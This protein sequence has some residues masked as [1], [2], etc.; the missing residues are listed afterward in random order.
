CCDSAAA[1]GVGSGG[2]GGYLPL[3]FLPILGA[4]APD[5]VIDRQLGQRG[6]CQHFMART[7]DGLSPADPRFGVPGE[8]VANA[9]PRCVL[10]AGLAFD[11]ILTDPHLA[12]W[13]LVGAYALI[14]ALED[15]FSAAHVDRDAD[16]KI[17]HL[18][19]WT[20]I[21]W[22]YEILHGKPRKGFPAATHHAATD[23]GDYEYL[24]ASERGPDGRACDA[25]LHPYAVPEVCLT[26]R[27]L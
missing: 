9:S 11:G 6:Q 22:P 13:R 26:P 20:L 2:G 12:S 16:F 1:P 8:L 27:A 14:H 7:D 25:Y 3:L 23:D 15:S 5:L 10:L 18:L 17:I 19:S 24:R 4:G 21:D